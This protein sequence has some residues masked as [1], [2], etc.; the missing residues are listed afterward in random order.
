MVMQIWQTI[1]EWSGGQEESSVHDLWGSHLRFF[2]QLVSFSPLLLSLQD[3]PH[4]DKGAAPQK[5]PQAVPTCILWIHVCTV[6]ILVNRAWALGD[7][8]TT[9]K[10]VVKGPNVFPLWCS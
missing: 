1:L 8:C 2:R 3:V 4:M 10:H 5:H 6:M 9:A 7:M